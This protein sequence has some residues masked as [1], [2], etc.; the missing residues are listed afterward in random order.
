[1]QDGR[2]TKIKHDLQSQNTF[3]RIVRKAESRGMVVNSAKTKVLCISDAMSYKARSYLTDQDGQDIHSGKTMKVLGFHMDSRPTA[4]AHVR[5]LHI[6]MRDN[7]WVL[8]HLK[9]SGFTEPELAVVYRT[10]IRPILDYCAIVYL[11]L[12]HTDAADE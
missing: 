8:R 3:R 11:S 12:I 4:H 1:M 5:A 9:L 7:V 10:V 6:R 2:P